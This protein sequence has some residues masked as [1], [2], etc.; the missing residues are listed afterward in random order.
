MLLFQHGPIALGLELKPLGLAGHVFQIGKQNPKQ[1]DGRPSES[2]LV[3]MNISKR[4]EKILERTF[5]N[6]LD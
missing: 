5:E 3:R 4:K 2:E 6:F 1:V